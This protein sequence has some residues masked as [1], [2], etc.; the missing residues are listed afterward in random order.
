MRGHAPKSAGSSECNSHRPLWGTLTGLPSQKLRAVWSPLTCGVSGAPGLTVVGLVVLC[1][2]VT[3]TSLSGAAMSQN[4][5]ALEG[6]WGGRGIALEITEAGT[7]IEYDCAFGSIDGP[8]LP[9]S[10]GRFEATGTHSF[11]MGGPRVEGEAAP[12]GHLA[13]YEGQVSDDVM[14]LHVVLPESDRTLGP[15]ELGKEGRARL[16]KCL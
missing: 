9:D 6:S 2:G 5:D 3:A 15:F 10:R 14:I 11:E 16:D 4:P 7:T 12:K 13:R 1:L 8:L